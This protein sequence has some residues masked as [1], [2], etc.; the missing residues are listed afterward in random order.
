VRVHS[1]T[2]FAFMGVCDETPGFFSWLATLQPLCHGREPKA[3]V[4]IVLMGLP[5]SKV[6]IVE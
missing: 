1:F 4:V 2:F 5:F 3:R 6:A